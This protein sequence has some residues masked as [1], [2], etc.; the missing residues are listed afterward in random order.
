MHP[1]D[2]APHGSAPAAD[3]PGHLLTSGTWAD[4]YALD[5]ERVLRRYREGRDASPEVEL[6]RHVR[7][8]DFP[9]PDVLDAHGSDI[10][11]NRLHGPTLLQ[12]LGAAEITLADAAQVLADL[13]HLLHDVPAPEGWGSA[14][15]RDWPALAGGPV[16]VHLDLHPGNVV[17][18]E[19]G[20][21]LVDWANARAGHAELDV[22]VTALLVAEV[23]VD[24]GGDYSQAARALLAAFLHASQ[25]SPRAAIDDAAGL[26][27]VTPG[28]LAGERE[29]VPRGAALVRSLLD[30][31]G[32]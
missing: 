24:A 13:H 6:L 21:T 26:R 31:T 7:A 10:V 16:V 5:D 28:L 1:G 25:V 8:H 23:A 3:V 9:A 20:P 2:V 29:L 14:T 27:S 30:L 18:T 11:M 32:S 12:A 4:V 19:H 15:A 17:L 22:A